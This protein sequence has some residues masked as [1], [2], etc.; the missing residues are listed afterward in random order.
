[1]NDPDRSGGDAAA[2]VPFVELIC[3]LNEVLKAWRL[4]HVRG[5]L[6]GNDGRP[7]RQR[8]IPTGEPPHSLQQPRADAVYRSSSYPAAHL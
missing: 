7:S 4:L 2:N 5:K 8:S 1:M 6:R 3:F